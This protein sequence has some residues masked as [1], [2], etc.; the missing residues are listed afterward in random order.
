MDEEELREFVLKAKEV[1]ECHLEKDIFFDEKMK[2][3]LSIL[4]KK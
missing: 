2:E 4:D 1:V 3:V